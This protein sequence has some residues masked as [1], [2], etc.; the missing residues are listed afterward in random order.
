MSEIINFHGQ[1]VEIRR[2]PLGGVERPVA[3]VT[4]TF[5]LFKRKTG[6]DYFKLTPED[7]LSNE[8]ALQL[9][10]CAMVVG[11]IVTGET[12]EI[13]FEP[14]F[15]IMCDDNVMFALAGIQKDNEVPAQEESEKVEE[16]NGQSHSRSK[17]SKKRAVEK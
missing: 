1:T 13:P 5:L 17:S 12:F 4:Y 16:K 15:L 8:D 2:V 7:E 9:Y 14:D 11:G 6:I 3:F 10:H